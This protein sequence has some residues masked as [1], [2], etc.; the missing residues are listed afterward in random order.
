MSDAIRPTHYA[1][2]PS[3]IEPWQIAMH[4]PGPLM[5]AFVYV[6]RHRDKDAPVDDLRKALQWMRF[7]RVRRTES[8]TPD[9]P[10][11]AIARLERVLEA[12]HH[13]GAAL[14]LIVNAA[15]NWMNDD[16]LT[17]AEVEVRRLLRLEMGE[18]YA[19]SLPW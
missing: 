10:S 15:I 17:A 16:A 12:G 2:H 14:D 1:G 19:R 8:A 4:L 3:G 9:V 6:W 5:D 18:E 7:E 11:I 13:A